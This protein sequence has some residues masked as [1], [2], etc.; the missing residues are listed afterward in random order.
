M[1]EMLHCLWDKIMKLIT[2]ILDFIYFQYLLFTITF[3][4]AGEFR[5][6]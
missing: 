3:F 2:K 4:P 6:L 5:G 1:P